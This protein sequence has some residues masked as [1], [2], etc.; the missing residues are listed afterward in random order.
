[1]I[2]EQLHIVRGIAVQVKLLV[3]SGRGSKLYFFIFICFSQESYQRKHLQLYPSEL[4]SVLV[5]PPEVFWC[6]KYQLQMSL[7]K[8]MSL[9]TY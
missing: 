8:E 7:E 4:S 9:V 6:L 1:V 3:A 5:H 2:C